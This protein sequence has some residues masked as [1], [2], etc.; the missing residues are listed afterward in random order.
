VQ[1]HLHNSS[2]VTICKDRMICS[3]A[4]VLPEFEITVDEVFKKPELPK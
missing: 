1:V 4:P 3:A 2:Q